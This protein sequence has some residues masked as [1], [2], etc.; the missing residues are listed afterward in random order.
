MG[1]MDKVLMPMIIYASQRVRRMLV[2]G[3]AAASALL[4]L[5]LIISLREAVILS[6][7][8]QAREELNRNWTI[9]VDHL[10]VE[11]DRTSK[12][13]HGI[14]R[15]SASDPAV[16]A[17]VA[18][19]RR[20]YL[21]ADATGQVLEASPNYRS[22]GLDDAD[23]IR[24]ALVSSVAVWKEKSD[25]KGTAYLIRAGYLPAGSDPERKVYVAIGT[26]LRRPTEYFGRF[27]AELGVV[28]LLVLLTGASVAWHTL[29]GT[30]QL[31]RVLKK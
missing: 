18:S 12:T 20:V 11:A 13:V 14:W 9:V 6:V 28:V 2:V 22:L 4:A 25:N 1:S 7:E 16:N 31:S 5:H 3:F 27:A 30:K 17:E 26:S 23:D 8:H 10:Q 24:N 15:I 29:T 19:V 21:V